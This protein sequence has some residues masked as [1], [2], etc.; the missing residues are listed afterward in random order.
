MSDTTPRIYVASL[1]DYNAGTLHGEWIDATQDVEDINAEIAEMLS[2][3]PT[4]DQHPDTPAEEWAIHDYDNF[5][6]LA[7]T[8]GEYPSIERVSAIAQAIEEH[9]NAFIAWYSS[10]DGDYN[11]P[12]TMS[13]EFED[14]FQGEFD[15]AADYA[16]DIAEECSTEPEGGWQNWPFS[17][18][19]WEHAAR[20]L[21]IGGDITVVE[22]GYKSVYVFRS[23]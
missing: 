3:S 23:I 5:G 20:E 16:Q 13:S 10:C 17:C 8:L 22:N 21:T 11:G 6:E 7:S 12:E 14:M 18:I 19:D 2:K 9:G 1:S 4:G 15:S